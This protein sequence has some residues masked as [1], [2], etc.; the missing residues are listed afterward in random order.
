[1]C[2]E[3]ST[4][5]LKGVCSSGMLGLFIIVGKDENAQPLSLTHS[6]TP[7]MDVC[8]HIHTL[9]SCSS[10]AHNSCCMPPPSKRERDIGIDRASE[11]AK[12]NKGVEYCMA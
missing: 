4:A 5:D 3:R 10:A 1:M 6:H 7:C 11:K 2:G 8:A 12:E 9:T